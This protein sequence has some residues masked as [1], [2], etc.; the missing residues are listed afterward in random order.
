MPTEFIGRDV[1]VDEL[2]VLV[3][4]HRLVTITGVGG[5][6]KTRLAVEVG[7]TLADRFAGGVWFVDLTAERNGDK[8]GDR[9]LA[10]SGW[11]D[12]HGS[13]GGE[14]V[15]MLTDATERL[16]TLLII[17]NCE[18]LIDA[19]AEFADAVLARAPSVSMLATSRE[20]LSVF[21]ERA[22]RIPNLHDAS[23]ELFVDRAAA[24]GVSGLENHLDQIEE[25]CVRL[26]NI[27]LA[28]ELAA[29]RVSSLSIDEL[30]ARL[31]DRFSLLGGDRRGRRQRQQ[32]LQTMMDWS[33]GLLEDTERAVLNQ[34][35]VF[36][37]T[38]PISGAAAVAAPADS[39]ILEILDSLV[40]QSLVV[41]SV[42]SGRYR[43][44]ETVRL[45]ALDRLMSS[46]ELVGARDQHL[47]WMLTLYG[48]EH[49]ASCEPDDT[50]DME[51]QKSVETHNAITAMEWAEQKGDDA[52]LLDLFV[53]GMGHL[54]AIGGPVMSWL[55]RVPEP[56]PH[57]PDLRIDW[58]Q[59]SG[60]LRY[61][62]GDWRAGLQQLLEAAAMIDRLSA[63]DDP[64]PVNPFARSCTE[65]VSGRH[66][67]ITKV[68]ST[69]ANGY[70]LRQVEGQSRWC[71]WG[72]VQTRYF[73]LRAQASPDALERRAGGGWDSSDPRPDN[74]RHVADQCGAPS[75]HRRPFRRSIAG[76]DAVPRLARARTIV[77]DLGASVRRKIARRPRAV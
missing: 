54:P 77:Q 66:R 67:G 40:E 64:F 8:V 45:Y 13:N 72:S 44:L 36:V 32:T 29:S 15:D 30:A 16:P 50:W 28:I 56:P 63:T 76:S 43:L 59:A 75:V 52:A 55:D 23:V 73:I 60:H 46:D 65:G 42:D 57:R 19:V 58:L 31:D 51:E 4:R 48:G 38:F 9:T 53:G 12:S 3:D 49:F 5:C 6:G 70:S 34:L 35:S 41:P 25:I 24:A 2:R 69:T 37:G 21:G 62:A 11:F 47:A 68:H 71:E 33:Y 27:P 61:G 26:D 14:S 39:S 18:H 17:D 74:V 10:A 7:A 1:E 20:S 22:W